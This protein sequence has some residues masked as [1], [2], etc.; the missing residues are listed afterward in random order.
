MT[1]HL[2]KI[3]VRVLP[4][5][6]LVTLI[7]NLSS[8]LRE[9]VLWMGVVFVSVLFHELGHATVGLAFGLE[10][11]IDL[12]G[13]GGTTS[14]A[15]NQKLSTWRR[16]AISLA[17][18]TAGFVLAAVA[19]AAWN[20][21]AFP[22]TQVAHGVYVNVLWVNVGWG[23]LNLLPMLPLDGG[24]VLAL[25]LGAATKGR[26]ERPAHIVSIVVA[27]A[28]AGLAL[29]LQQ[30]WPA[31]LAASFVAANV[32]GL[33]ALAAREHDAPMRRGL[34]QAYEALEAKD[35]ER[36]LTLARPAALTSK[37]PQVRAE[38][39]QLMAFGFL[40]TG[41]LADADAAIAALPKGFSPHPSLTELRAR[42]QSELPGAAPPS[43]PD[44]EPQGAP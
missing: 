33:Q 3:P 35:G 12:H 27:V 21:G 32:R 34:E 36:I 29:S 22:R 1:F 42:V 8:G 11:R 26:G 28:S 7:F 18:P 14:W 6:F 30:W 37:T 23:L 17:G 38:A 4:S 19:Y 9:L 40:L 43:P 2:G 25:L 31:L 5:F 24:N 15:V 10:P 13:M 39:L 41:R 16:V 44:G 20:G